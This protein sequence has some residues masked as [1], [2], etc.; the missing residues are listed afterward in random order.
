M[1]DR[2]TQVVTEALVATIGG[3]KARTSQVVT[4]VLI[5]GRAQNARASQ[6]VLEVLM[7]IATVPGKNYVRS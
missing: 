1:A 2:V 6:V 7:K 5:S 4:E 3:Q